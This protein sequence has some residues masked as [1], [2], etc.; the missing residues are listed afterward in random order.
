M[1]SDRPSSCTFAVPTQRRLQYGAASSLG[2]TP[3]PSV[4]SSY[5]RRRIACSRSS[6]TSSPTPPRTSA[7]P[8]RGAS[9][10]PQD[11]R[12]NRRTRLRASSFSSSP[13]AHER[14]VVVDS[15][16]A[17]W[18][19]TARASATSWAAAASVRTRARTWETASTPAL[20]WNHMRRA[21]ASR[22]EWRPAPRES[23]T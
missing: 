13:H 9:A 12:K 21:M 11:A 16:S 2:S 7:T 23:A 20:R 5:H 14:S 17:P 22:D 4:P 18:R 10:V 19:R 3:P 1:N 8:R 15:A 6:N